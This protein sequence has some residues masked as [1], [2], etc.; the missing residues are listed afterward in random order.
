MAATLEAI[1]GGGGSV[2]VGA[3]GTISTLMTREIESS[4]STASPQSLIPV[5]HSNCPLKPQKSMNEVSSNSSRS[6]TG[7]KHTSPET[8][9]KTKGQ[10]LIS[11][12]TPKRQKQKTSFK[13]RPH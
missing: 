6:T 11:T 13:I 5:V 7:I 2:K 3:I 1:K 4:S 9:S 12:S 10:N 8:L